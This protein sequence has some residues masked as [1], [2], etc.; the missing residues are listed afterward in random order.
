ME[1]IRSEQRYDVVVVGRGAWGSMAAIAAARSGARTLVIEQ[2][3]F[4]GGTLTAM[5]VWPRP[6]P[7]RGLGQPRVRPALRGPRRSPTNTSSAVR[8]RPRSKT[9]TPVLLSSAVACHG[10]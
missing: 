2:Y 8:P 1:L 7:G 4:L 9:S 5:G 10:A 3:G 6:R